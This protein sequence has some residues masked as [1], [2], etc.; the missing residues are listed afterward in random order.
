MWN[1]YCV[2]QW[3]KG[4][5]NIAY[6]NRFDRPA[7]KPEYDLGVEDTWWLDAKKAAMIEA[8]TAP[9]K[10]KGAQPP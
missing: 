7:V 2:P 6:W 8:G 9:P 4:S 10:P 1:R 5:H 3:Y